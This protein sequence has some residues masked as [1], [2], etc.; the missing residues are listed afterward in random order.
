MIKL[1]TFINLIALST[2]LYLLP[3]LS[4][5]GNQRYEVLS[6][7]T[8][9]MMSASISDQ[10]PIFS[11]FM[12]DQEKQTWIV[13]RLNYIKKRFIDEEEAINFLVTIHY[14]ATRAGLDPDLI[15]GLIKVES[16]FKKYAISSVGARGYMQIMPFWIDIIG[17]KNHNL[18]H[19]RTNLRY[20]CTILRH[21][22]DIEKG[23]IHRALGRYNGSL[24][25]DKYPNAV[26]NSVKILKEQA[27]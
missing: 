22:I 26:L 18:F 27:K 6:A 14:E 7:A 5:A 16:N 10:K 4:I 15:L 21:Y 9:Q 12:N 20:G 8:K 1:K 25:K 2:A 13:P 19:L 3:S 17:E 23:N 24:G 11:S